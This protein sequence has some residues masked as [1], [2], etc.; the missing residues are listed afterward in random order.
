[1]ERFP[2]RHYDYAVQSFVG[3]EELEEKVKIPITM[4]H[5]TSW[6][7]FKVKRKRNL[8]TKERF[9]EYFA[10]AAEMG[11]QS[12]SYDELATWRDSDIPLP[13]RPIMFDF[14]HPDWSI[15][16]VI[17]PIMQKHGF[18]GNLFIN[19]SPMEKA[20]NPFYMK[21]DDLR[22]LVDDGWHI[23]AHTYRH[24]RMDYLARKDPSGGLIREELRKCDEMLVEHLGI[25]PRDFAFTT[26]T[27]SHVAE[28]EVKRRY[29]F[30]RL[31]IVGAY[32]DTD[33]GRIRYADLVG[34]CGDDEEDGG[35]PAAAR[36][37][38][39]QTHAY[40]LPS[41]ELE[42]LI[43]DYDAFRAYLAGAFEE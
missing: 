20:E 3:T 10:I 26:T 1:M 33:K 12:I 42:E 19:T 36:Y 7:P 32:Y 39:R 17:W 41:M 30:G 18:R 14:D 22:A 5:G 27:W 25:I 23:G 4:S 38:T 37:I 34:V 24:Y 2:K 21:W 40:R 28:D 8:L 35:P 6:E 15:S 16:K 13:A 31:W 11:F 9:E 29:R 43:F